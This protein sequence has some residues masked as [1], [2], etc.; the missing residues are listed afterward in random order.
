MRNRIINLSDAEFDS[1]RDFDI[2]GTVIKLRR[3]FPKE[4]VGEPHYS[5]TLHARR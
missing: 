2:T 3:C 1:G 5:I 4:G